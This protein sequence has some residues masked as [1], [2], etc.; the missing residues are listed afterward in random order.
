M[1][2]RCHFCCSC[3]CWDLLKWANSHHQTALAAALLLLLV[4]LSVASQ[5]VQLLLQTHAV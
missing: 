3:R 4:L 1:K 2:R 5:A